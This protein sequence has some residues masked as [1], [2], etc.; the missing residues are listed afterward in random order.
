[1][2][3]HP[4]LEGL[5]SLLQL[6]SWFESLINYQGV[7]SF[8]FT[9]VFLFHQNLFHIFSFK[10]SMLNSSPYSLFPSCPLIFS[11]FELVD[12][13]PSRSLQISSLGSYDFSE[14]LVLTSMWLCILDYS[15]ILHSIVQ[16]HFL[17]IHYP[18][19]IT[20]Y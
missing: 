18:Y 13:Y 17:F 5:V 19:S 7:A 3:L 1:M 14:H 20:I 10:I 11:S 6:C 12:F 2:F 4:V 15:P 16:E 8:A 9:P